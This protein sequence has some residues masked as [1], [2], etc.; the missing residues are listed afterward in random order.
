[1]NIQQVEYVLAVSESNNFSQAAEK[2]FITQSTLSTMIARF[3][4]ELGITIFDRS[5]KPVGI[6]R[7]GEE[8]IRQLRIIQ[9]EI[10][11]LNEVVDSLKGH[12]TGEL[13]I[14][15]IPTVA[16][17]L[18][19][20]FLNDF[21][22]KLPDL[23]FVISEMTTAKILEKIEKRE[24]DIGIASLPLKHKDTIEIPI[25]TEPFLL[26]DRE[27]P[28]NSI[29]S[30]LE[31]LDYERL[32]LL[33]EG[34]CMRNQV[35]HIC[36]LKETRDILRNLEYKSGSIDTLLKFVNK[37]KGLT[38]LPLLATLDMPEEDRKY[39]RSME[40]PIPTRSIGLIVHK[41]FVK[42]NILNLIQTE[43]QLRILPLLGEQDPEQHIVSPVKA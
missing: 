29:L 21:V 12:L 26:Y 1:M 34:H 36:D 13:T 25:Y 40:K 43:I 35:E 8:V 37:N 10:R 15:I 2:C 23:H 16:P 18:L 17:Y 7:E 4:E 9:K 24:L 31:N 5:K 39:L 32:W 28:D 14:G 42:R 11:N 20:Y 30:T 22:Q 33:E 19:P 6:T 3:E 41:H 27:N 38:L